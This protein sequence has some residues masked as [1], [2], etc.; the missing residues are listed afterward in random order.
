MLE[1]NSI[2]SEM[3]VHIPMCTHKEPSKVLAILADDAIKNEL[4]KYDANVV[5]SDSF[6]VDEKFDVVI[7]NSDD[8]DDIVMANVMRSLEEKC[9]LFASKVASFDENS[10]L[11]KNDLT[12]VA[13]NF[14]IAMPYKSDA[15][16]MVLASKKYHP[17][18][19]I[20]LDRSDF[21]EA[22]YYNTELHNASFVMPSYI[23][24][25]LTGIAKR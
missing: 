18:A 8:L 16:M 5:Y 25:P 6:N 24:K 23:Q 20:I 15:G 11:M 7:Y 19:D 3:L 22:S 1:K 2:N 4:A 10:E 9:G 17:Q 13:K 14:W 12:T 21:I